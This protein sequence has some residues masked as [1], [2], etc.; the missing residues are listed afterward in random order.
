MLARDDAVIRVTHQQLA[1]APARRGE[2]SDPPRVIECLTRNTRTL[3]IDLPATLAV[4]VNLDAELLRGSG[5]SQI[6]A[7]REAEGIRTHPV[8]D[9]GPPRW[10][11][12]AGGEMLLSLIMSNVHAPEMIHSPA[13]PEFA[14]HAELLRR[15]SRLRTALEAA[16][17][18]NAQLQRQLALARAEN[19][20]L[21]EQNQGLPQH[22]ARAERR[23]MLSEQWS[24]NP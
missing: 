17:R 7:P 11:S 4:E 6:V 23:R 15:I 10:S 21:R 16:A 18:D 3:E 19:R 1:G 14:E 9:C 2:K 5:H 12:R 22:R 24:R 8:S 20:R 13:P